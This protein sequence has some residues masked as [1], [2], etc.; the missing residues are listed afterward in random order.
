MRRPVFAEAVRNMGDCI[1]RR[2]AGH[3][4]RGDFTDDVE[5][6]RFDT[7]GFDGLNIATL[8]VPG[9]NVGATKH[10][11]S[12]NDADEVYETQRVTRLRLKRRMFPPPACSILARS[13]WTFWCGF[14][15]M[16]VCL[17]TIELRLRLRLRAQTHLFKVKLFGSP[18]RSCDSHNQLKDCNI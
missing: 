5:N 14:W 17:R 1:V 16:L 13:K 10:V 9:R 4:F 3:A 18:E 2:I 11:W 12:G 15:V 6:A 7:R 8:L